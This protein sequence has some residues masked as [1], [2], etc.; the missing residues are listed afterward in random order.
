MSDETT[1][2]L[3]EQP[4]PTGTTGRRSWATGLH[5]VSIGHLVMGV[6]FIGLFVTWILIEAGGSWSQLRWMLPVPWVA[7]GLVGLVA[8]APRLRGT[9]SHLPQ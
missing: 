4:D 3:P 7:A 2:S 5:Q 1:E 6:A 9:E 8:A